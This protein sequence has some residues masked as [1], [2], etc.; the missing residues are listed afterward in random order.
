[1]APSFVAFQPKFN[2]HLSFS[3]IRAAGPANLT[4]VDLFIIIILVLYYASPLCIVTYFR[5]VTIRRVLIW[6]IGFVDIL[7]THLVTFSSLMLQLT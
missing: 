5:V 1:M 7:Y 3:Y 6:M 4:I 2:K